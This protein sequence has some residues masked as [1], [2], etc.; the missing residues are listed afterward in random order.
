[1]QALGEDATA[2]QA[3]SSSSEQAALAP[4]IGAAR[5]DPMQAESTQAES[6]CRQLPAAAPVPAIERTAQSD[7]D[8]TLQ[9]H[10]RK[11]ELAAALTVDW[12]WLGIDGMRNPWK[13]PPAVPTAPP[14]PP[15]AATAAPW[16]QFAQA[17]A[18]YITGR[19]T[20]HSEL[21]AAAAAA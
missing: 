19:P 7:D 20:A 4:S 21:P 6:Q 10:A 9:E 16:W 8:A 14:T 2:A 11:A 13:P 18:A 17:A 5:N 3:K 15:P 1:M 12:D